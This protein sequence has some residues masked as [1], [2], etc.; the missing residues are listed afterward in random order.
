L[1][2]AD[3][4]GVQVFGARGNFLGRIP[5]EQ[6]TGVVRAIAL[7]REG[8]AYLLTLDGVV[9]KYRINAPAK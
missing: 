9:S 6:G 4:N 8:F 7:D 2:V 5:R 1:F 3:S